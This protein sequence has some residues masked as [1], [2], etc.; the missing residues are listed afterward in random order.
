MLLGTAPLLGGGDRHRL[1]GAW[2]FQSEVDT[3]ADG[4]P[5]PPG[6]AAGDCEGLLIYTADGFMS[7]TIM[8]KA[9][10]WS[11]DTAT[12]AELRDTVSNGTAYAGRYELNEATHTV[13]HIPDVTMEPGYEHKR[14]VRTYSFQG[15][16]LQLSG[17]FE[18]QGETIHFTLTWVPVSPAQR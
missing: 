11:T 13:T 10:R 3:K 1:V 14:L 12:I 2:R 18:Y 17:T 6:A 16:S 4:S 15:R 9:R 8:P 5:A 7:V